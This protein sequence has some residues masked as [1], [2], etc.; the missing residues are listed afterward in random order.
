MKVFIYK[1]AKTDSIMAQGIHMS[2][3][4]GHESSTRIKDL[5]ILVSAGILTCEEIDLNAQ[6]AAEEAKKKAE[7]EAKAKE[8]KAAEE[9][10]KAE[11]AKK[12]AEA[13]SKK[14]TPNVD[15]QET[16]SE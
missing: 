8:L 13:K 4:K 11:K 6:K 3:D 15:Q 9:A 14:S 1:P 5:D 10:K 7:E 16:D 12:A 2:K